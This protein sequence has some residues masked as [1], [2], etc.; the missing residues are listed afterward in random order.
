MYNSVNVVNCFCCL[1]KGLSVRCPEDFDIVQGKPEFLCH[2]N[3]K[4]VS[5]FFPY[6]LPGIKFL[7]HLL[8]TCT[9]ASEGLESILESNIA[10]SFAHRIWMW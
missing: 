9:T 2:I 4:I 10:P 8:L 3:A 5:V 7:E 6:L 1:E